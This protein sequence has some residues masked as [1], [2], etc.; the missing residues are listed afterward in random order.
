MSA[1]IHAYA[2]SITGRR[3][4][5]EDAYLLGESIGVYAVLDGMGGYAGGQVA[6]TTAVSVI[7]HFFEVIAQNPDATW[8]YAIDPHKS[9]A[10]NQ[11]DAAIRLANRSIRARRHDELANM[12][13]TIVLLRVCGD[14]AVIGHLGD[15]RIY[16][17]R[18]GELQ[19]LTCDHSLYEHLRAGGVELPPLAE[20]VHGNV[21]T[22][23][24]GPHED[25]RPEL[26]LIDIAAGDRFLLCTDGLCGALDDEELTALLAEGSAEEASAALIEVAFEN[27]S[28]DN[29]TALVV[30]FAE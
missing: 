23:A 8:P 9:L 10:E 30:D 19:Q 11:V 13:S 27:G 25:E 18:A 3:S 2:Q 12:G 6:S 21:I 17:L 5:N 16:R 28:R 29:I 20:F 4:R 14:K 22:R 24:L 7:H 26:S 1:S 15:S